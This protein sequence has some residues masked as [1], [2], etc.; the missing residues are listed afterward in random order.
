MSFPR[1]IVLGRVA[2]SR[3][4]SY[5]NGASGAVSVPNVLIYR[6]SGPLFFA[7]SSQFR[8]RIEDLVEQSGEKINLVILDWSGILF[9]DL[10]G[11]E[12]LIDL[13]HKLGSMHIRLA[14]AAVHETLLESLGCGEVTDALGESSIF[15]SID[16][17]VP[18]LMSTSETVL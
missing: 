9:M 13:A 14:L 7:N 16:A 15:S 1:D 3:E 8:S 11:C 6:F 2:S 5:L 12:T 4:F 17:A 18:P 10:A